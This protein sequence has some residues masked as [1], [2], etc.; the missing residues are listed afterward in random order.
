MKTNQEYK[1]A[2]LSRIRGNWSP[3]VLATII[4][5]IIELICCSGGLPVLK[6]TLGI[7]SGASF[8]LTFFVVGPL[9]VGYANASRVLYETGNIDMS[10]NL[11][12]F[13]TVNYLHKV[14]GI[15]FSTLKV[16]LWT[17]LLVVPGI[18]MA[19]AYAL[20]PYILEENPEISAW[21]ASTRS[22]EMMQGHKFDLFYL[23]LSFIGWF[24]L[25]IITFGIGF[26]WL[27]PYAQTSVAAFYNDLK[28]GDGNPT[29]IVG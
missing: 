15:F 9:I 17:L 2:A 10:Q 6:S 27:I 21:D 5:I 24:L 8:I 4:F 11:W 14:L 16:V 22:R 20:T 1:E 19:F 25:S 3:I 29:I 13:S 7:A 18:I 26:I 28:G 12:N 23:Y